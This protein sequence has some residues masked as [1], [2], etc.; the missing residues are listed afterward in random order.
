MSNYFMN[1]FGNTN[2]NS[3]MNFFNNIGEY[4]S[5]TNGA[6]GK[7]LRSYYSKVG[8]NQESSSAASQILNSNSSTFTNSTSTAVSSKEAKAVKEETDA[9]KESAQALTTTGDKS[10]F[11]KKEVTTT[12]EKTGEKSTSMQYDK[13]KI[14][15]AVKSFVTDYNSTL[16]SVDDLSNK[17][18]SRTASYMTK[19]TEIYKKSLDKVGITIG[20]DNTLTVN[21]DKLK[22]ADMNMVKN[23][24]NGS[25]S[26]ASQTSQKASQLQQATTIAA[27]NSYLYNGTGSY[28]STNFYSTF[29]RYF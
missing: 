29:N 27:N 28:T 11:I 14:V 7:L 16:D 6:Y 15:N 20:T 8:A 21:E 12:D 24:F 25:Y 13:D 23:L 17:N 5:I 26:F 3:S 22:N 4:S 19:Q 18:V 10:L 2:S 9:L 1:L